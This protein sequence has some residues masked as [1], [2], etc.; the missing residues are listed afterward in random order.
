MRCLMVTWVNV[1]STLF[2]AAA[3]YDLTHAANAAAPTTTGRSIAIASRTTIP[4]VRRNLEKQRRRKLHN[5][6]CVLLPE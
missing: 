2:F 6:I 1:V 5:V 3:D 4:K